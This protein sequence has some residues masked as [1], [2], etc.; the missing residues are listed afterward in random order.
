M[1]SRSL[2]K[3]NA[4]LSEIRSAGLKGSLSLIQIDVTS[5]QSISA[6]ASHVAEKFGRLD[7]LVNNAGISSKDPSLKR[8]FEDT[9]AA[10]VIGPVLMT[11]A[12]EPLL[13]KSKRPYLMQISSGLGSLELAV[14]PTSHQ[15][16]VS[17]PAY[18]SSK[19]ALN[20]IMIDDHR[21]LGKQGVK[22]FSV[23]PGL[24]RSNL[25]GTEE[26]QISAGGIAVDATVSGELILS[27]IEGK[28]DAEAGQVIKKDGVWP[29]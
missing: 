29:W 1:T 22:V 17:L 20:M 28:R 4:A 16:K 15:S 3:G 14:T 25:R 2:K 23:C 24:V 18:N 21:R 10:N 19:A 8:K 11:A 5:E 7:V 27:V 13:L 6:A 9:Y 12:F 26:E